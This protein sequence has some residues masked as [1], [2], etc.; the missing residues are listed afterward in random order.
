M[1]DFDIIKEKYP[2]AFVSKNQ[3]AID[4]GAMFA[5]YSV[6]SHSGSDMKELGYGETEIEALRNAVIWLED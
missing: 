3:A 4:V 1:M 5:A 6:W 2:E